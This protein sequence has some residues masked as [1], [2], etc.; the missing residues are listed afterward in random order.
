MTRMPNV[1]MTSPDEN[2]WAAA[3]KLI[4]HQI[5]GMPV[6][7]SRGEEGYEVVGRFTKTNVTQAFVDIGYG[8]AGEV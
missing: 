3:K 5:D 6:V 1:V 7:G 4:R 2:L 8:Q